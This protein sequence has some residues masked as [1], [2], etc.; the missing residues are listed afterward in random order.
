MLLEDPEPLPRRSW[1]LTQF[2]F[3]EKI[4]KNLKVPTATA[5]RGWR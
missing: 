5:L 4:F 3:R 1:L 2:Q